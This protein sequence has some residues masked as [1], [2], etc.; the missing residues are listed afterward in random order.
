[1]DP[2]ST[3]IV[4]KTLA[5]SLSKFI[6]E[7]KFEKQEVLP[8]KVKT[9]EDIEKIKQFWIEKD[10]KLPP[11][12]SWRLTEDFVQSTFTSISQFRQE[13][14]RQA[15]ATFN[16]ALI[17]T[18]IGVILI[19][20]GIMLFYLDKISA[21][22]ISTSVGAIS[23][24]TSVILFKLNKD[25]NDR[26]D[27]TAKDLSILERLRIGIYYIDQIKDFSKRDEAIQQLTEDIQLYQR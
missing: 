26:L 16:F 3:V 2:I 5:E 24:V 7:N 8:E 18:I 22:I 11:D 10:K 15:R 17:F 9:K 4:S 6:K 27:E 1:M 25:S 23:E 13:R 14:L 12:Q 20:F 21:G 19:F